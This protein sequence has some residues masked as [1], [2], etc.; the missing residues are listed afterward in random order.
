MSRIEDQAN[1]YK[2]LHL[3][4]RS[5]QAVVHV[6]NKDDEAFWNF[7][8]QSVLPGHYHFVSQSRS[9]AGIES[10]GCEQCLRYC[11]YINRQFFICIDSDLRLLRGEEGLTPENYIAQT[12]AYSWENHSCE[13]THLEYRFTQKVPNCEFSFVTFLNELSRIVYRPLLY[14]VYHKTPD[15]NQRWNVTK[16]NSCIPIQ[17]KREEL[18]D[19]GRPYL[20]KVRELFYRKMEALSLPDNF[21]VNGLTPENAYLHIQGHQLYKLIAYIG[22]LMCRG[23]RV[24]FK[25]EILNKE[26][27]ILGYA[28]I[29]NVQSDLRTILLE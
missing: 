16:F 4:D 29:E 7:Q 2:N 6:E 13:A 28:E 24:A 12:Y 20:Q 15:L 21:S 19:N 23:M 22:K 1:Y 26:F 10:N 9:E 14:L 3:R 18:E 27:P 11:P 5:I 25:S 17:P 8:L